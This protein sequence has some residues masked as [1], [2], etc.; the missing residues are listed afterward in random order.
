MKSNCKMEIRSDFLP[1]HC[2]WVM[3]QNRPERFVVVMVRITITET[4]EKSVVYTIATDVGPIE[5]DSTKVFATR[6]EL[7]ESIFG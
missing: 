5:Y 2:V 6:E 3:F 4:M 1:G 7:K